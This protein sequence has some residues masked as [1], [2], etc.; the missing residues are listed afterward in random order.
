[1]KQKTLSIKPVKLGGLPII[2]T[3]ANK[4]GLLKLFTTH[5]AADPRDKISVAQTLYVILCN[6]IL[7]RFPLYKMSDWAVQRSLIP[8]NVASCFND[9]RVG[10]ALHRLFR[11]DRSALLT[12]VVL[13]AIDEYQLDTHR[14][15]NDSTTVT[16]FGQ[17]HVEHKAAVPARGHNKDHRPD[18]KQLLFNLSVCGDEAVPLYF[19]VWDGNTTDDRTHLRNWMA[20]RGLLGKKDFTYV[21][22][23]KLCTRENMGFIDSEGGVFITVIPETRAEDKKFKDWIQTNT[24]DWKEVKRK[25]GKQ[26]YEHHSVWWA[27]ES[28]FLSSEGFR[29]LWIKSSDKET[30]DENKRT[31]R[32]EKTEEAFRSLQTQTHKNQSKLEADIREVLKE[33]NT[34]RYFHWQVTQNVTETFKQAHRGRPRQDTQYRKI[35]KT[36]YQFSWSHNQDAIRY[37]AKCDGIFPLITNLRKS[38]PTEVLEIYKYQ[39]RLEKRHEQLK[40]VYNVAPVFLKHPERIEALLFLYFLGLLLTALIERTVRI[41]MK[42]RGV[43]SIPIYPEQR[44]CRKPTADKVL[45]LFRDVRRQTLFKNNK[46]LQVIDDDLSETQMEVLDLLGIA[47]EVFFHALPE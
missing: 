45:D 46:P 24:P 2:H 31:T 47:P 30:L 14:V 37:D 12:Q 32:I 29:I 16:L 15:H 43:D 36:G 18:L 17:Y 3:L 33:Q 22:D 4:L 7:E 38:T 27:I 44:E 25:P 13:K 19:K 20:L 5:V 11:S 8:D 39:P 9:D 6:I 28:P 35:E 21:A 10:R 26:K 1:M 42:S 41:Q 40:S 23:S 34:N